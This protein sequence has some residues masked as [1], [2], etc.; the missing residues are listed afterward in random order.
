MDDGDN[1]VEGDNTSIQCPC[2]NELF[3]ETADGEPEEGTKLE[4]RCGRAMT[5]TVCDWSAYVVAVVART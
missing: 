4:C 3:F 2:G 1:E 5:V